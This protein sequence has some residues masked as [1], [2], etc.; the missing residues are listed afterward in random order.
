MVYQ[1]DN[2]EEAY[3]LSSVINSNYIDSLIK[4]RQSRGSFGERSIVK[5]PLEF[6]IPLFNPDND[7]HLEL[8][9][10]GEEC[11]EL[12]RNSQF[13]ARKKIKEVL[14]EQMEEIDTL[15]RSLLEE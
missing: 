13:K 9:R 2:R 3:Y 15:I 12:V 4:E 1:T 5:L 7:D 11:H 14:S 10:L 6:A 8:V